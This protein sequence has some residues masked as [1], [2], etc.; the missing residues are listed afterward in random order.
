MKLQEFKDLYQE[1]RV[2]CHNEGIGT[3]GLNAFGKQLGLD[4][5][6]I[7]DFIVEWAISQG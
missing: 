3:M 1:H 2:E 4:N 7:N 5:E 6:T